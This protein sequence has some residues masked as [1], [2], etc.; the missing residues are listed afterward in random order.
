MLCETR[1]TGSCR[2]QYVT[3]AEALHLQTWDDLGAS[4]T[5][6]QSRRLSRAGRAS[7]NR[8]ALMTRP[9]SAIADSLTFSNQNLTVE[10][11]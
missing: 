4:F 8:F 2:Q 10:R 6:A 7:T 3:C 5:S 11:E 1:S 9:M